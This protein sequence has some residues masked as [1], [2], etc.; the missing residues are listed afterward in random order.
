MLL[1]TVSRMPKDF[2]LN[3]SFSGVSLV[4]HVP[5]NFASNA[6][7]VLQQTFPI[8][9]ILFSWEVPVFSYSLFYAV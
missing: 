4:S 3:P 5:C 1:M 7:Q 2:G 6:S 9:F 8:K